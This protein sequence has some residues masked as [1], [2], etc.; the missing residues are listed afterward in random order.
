M[1]LSEAPLLVSASKYHIVV[2]DKYD[3]Y[4]LNSDFA[5][6]DDWKLAEAEG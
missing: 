1:N 3:K 2:Q 5:N 6:P 4:V